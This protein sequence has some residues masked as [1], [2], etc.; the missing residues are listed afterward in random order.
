V[1]AVL[2]D[3]AALASWAFGHRAWQVL[4]GAASA[5]TEL[6]LE[7]A[8][9]VRDLAEVTP[10]GLLA[11]R[12]SFNASCG[13]LGALDSVRYLFRIDLRDS[14]LQVTDPALP[15]DV[16]G[17]LADTVVALAAERRQAQSYLLPIS[18]I[19]GEAAGRPRALFISHDLPGQDSAIVWGFEADQETF[20]SV[21]RQAFTR[22]PILPPVL[23][24]ELKNDSLMEV[25]VTDR[26][27]K[28]WFRSGDPGVG[29]FHVED[30]LPRPL[31]GLRAGLSIRAEA[32]PLLVIGGLPRSRRPLLL[33]LLGLSVG[34][35]WV[36]LAQLQREAA[37]ARQRSDFVSGVSHELRTP[38]AQI[39]IFVETLR[40]GRIRSEEERARSLE[41]IDQ[42][43]RRLSYL[44]ENV[45]HFSRSERG[46]SQLGLAPTPI[47][48]LT[49]EIV[50]AF[51]PL[52]RSR[53]AEV[54]T[55]LEPGLVVS[56]DRDG[57]RQ[58]LLN[59]LDNAMRY[60]P[61]GQVVRVEVAD[62]G[63]APGTGKVVRVVVD[64]EGPGIDP[65]DRERIFE[66]FFRL[67]RDMESASG[68]SGIG[69]A[70]V[71]ELVRLHGGRVGAEAAPGGGARLVVELPGGRSVQWSAGETGSREAESPEVAGPG[72]GA[73]RPGGV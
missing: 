30:T 17:W 27:G 11:E 49:A 32:A 56:L 70:V 58:I 53:R 31:G 28:V 42:E 68:G 20:E 55:T 44:V 12:E 36:A 40:L 25:I 19:V 51:R 2:Q 48:E 18:V 8:R 10:E 7:G 63:V 6:L 5:T 65:R 38:L 67:G 52:A 66:P 69:L 39:R 14:S 24:G 59:L 41:I 22:H 3:Y 62:A 21:L 60:G 26:A 34:L 15:A 37:L 29:G 46:A 1:E 47:A 54:A 71:R 50:E 13:C 16:R 72:P 57:F 23:T 43:A 61:A 45:L 64:D 33:T 9:G 4:L 35:V 73:T